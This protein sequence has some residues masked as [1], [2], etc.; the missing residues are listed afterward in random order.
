MVIDWHDLMAF[1]RLSAVWL[2]RPITFRANDYS[3]SF[4]DVDEVRYMRTY[5]G[6]VVGLHVVQLFLRSMRMN[7]GNHIHLVF[8]GTSPRVRVD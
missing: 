7:N 3:T 5:T 2:G 8:W 6:L 1:H 4:L